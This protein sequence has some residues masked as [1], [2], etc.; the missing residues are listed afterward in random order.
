MFTQFSRE[1]WTSLEASA[2][3]RA[4]Y[5]KGLF[6]E[7]VGEFKPLFYL[8]VGAGLG[9]NSLAFGESAKEI[10]AVDLSFP[11][12]NVLRGLGNI[13]MIVADARFL[14][15]RNTMFDAVS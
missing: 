2:G 5:L 4:K 12:D 11:K 13:H 8:D 10:V 14:P 15:F 3:E 6:M 1:I 7:A 9:Y